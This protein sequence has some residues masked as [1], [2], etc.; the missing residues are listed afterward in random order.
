MTKSGIACNLISLDRQY[1]DVFDY[2][3]VFDKKKI[4]FQR[5]GIKSIHYE[6]V[7]NPDYN[8]NLIFKFQYVKTQMDKV[9]MQS[10]NQLSNCLLNK[11]EPICTGSDAYIALRV[12]EAIIKSS[13]EMKRIYL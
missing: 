10:V 6:L 5:E 4:E 8:D 13:V 9:M 1:F 7:S 11:E 12:A 3:L 2:T